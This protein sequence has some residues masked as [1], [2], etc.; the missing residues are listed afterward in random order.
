[1]Q[2]KRIGHSHPPLKKTLDAV[3]GC[4]LV[5]GMLK[6]HTSHAPPSVDNTLPQPAKPSDA[7]VCSCARPANAYALSWLMSL[8]PR[9]LPLSKA[10]QF[11]TCQMNMK[12]I[13][14]V[15]R[16]L[17]CGRTTCMGPPSMHDHSVCMAQ[18]CRMHQA[19]MCG[20]PHATLHMPCLMYMPNHGR[21][22]IPQLF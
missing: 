1:M 10:S 17:P 18:R 2:C 20:F 16:S 14:R 7:C 13:C 12:S 8:H 19:C 22:H 3:Q 4:E 9:I 6:P 11:H 5:W 21:D 15:E